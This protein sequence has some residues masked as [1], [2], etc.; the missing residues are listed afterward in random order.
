M[1]G[2]I[3]CCQYNPFIHAVCLVSSSQ[4]PYDGPY[5]S[6]DLITR[7]H[8]VVLSLAFSTGKVL[9]NDERRKKLSDNQTAV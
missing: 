3:V 7:C 9:L 5:R 8:E 2:T 1:A 6:L 4:A